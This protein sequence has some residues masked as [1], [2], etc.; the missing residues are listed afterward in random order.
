[1]KETRGR[2]GGGCGGGW[3]WQGE[4]GGDERTPCA[5][6]HRLLGRASFRIFR[7]RPGGEGPC[8]YLEEEGPRERAIACA[9][10]PGKQGKFEV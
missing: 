7:L 6:C 8:E 2:G 5:E 1:M 3:H 9:K 4:W 10:I